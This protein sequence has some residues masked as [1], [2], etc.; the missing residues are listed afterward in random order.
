MADRVV[1][2]TKEEVLNAIKQRRK[3]ALANTLKNLNL[4]G[5]NI[6]SSGAQSISDSLKVNSTLT[7]LILWN[8]NIDSSGAQSISDSLKVNDT[9]TELELGGNNIGEALLKEIEKELQNNEDPNSEKRKKGKP[10]TPTPAI[11]ITNSASNATTKTIII[12]KQ[13]QKRGGEKILCPSSLQELLK[14]GGEKLGIVAVKARTFTEEAMIGDI[15]V[16]KEDQ[17]IV[18][19]TQEDEKEF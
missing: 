3:F 6:G 12:R 19:T 7:T 9:L 8:N 17:L 15:S 10:P 1:C 13:G 5:D 2:G 18:L 14:V 11:P 4:Y 16:I